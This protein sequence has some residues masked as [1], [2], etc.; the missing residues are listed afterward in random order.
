[1]PI[2]DYGTEVWFQSK[3]ITDIEFVQLWFLKT[4]L[5]IKVQASN[6]IVYADTGRFPLLLRQQDIVL[7]YLDRLRGMD[8]YKPIYKVYNELRNLHEQGHHTWYTRALDIIKSC[9]EHPVSALNVL[10]HDDN[11]SLY[12]TTKS[13]RYDRSQEQL[14]NDINNIEQNPILR[15]YRKFKNIS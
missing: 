8:K 10:I 11:M 13:S 4:T 3:P 7:K 12:R 6:K 2:L 9:Q 1:M 15:T 14:F 5:G